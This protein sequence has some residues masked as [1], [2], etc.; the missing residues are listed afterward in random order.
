[1]A[2]LAL[3]NREAKRRAT[4]KKFAEKRKALFAIIKDP[5]ATDEA[6][7]AALAKLQA[8]PRDASPVRLRN[9]CAITGR[10]RGTFRKFGLARSKIREIAMRGEIPGM[11]KASW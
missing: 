3:I 4:V 10:P 6:R 5:K 9:R 7:D 2:K 8:L 11:I 1:M